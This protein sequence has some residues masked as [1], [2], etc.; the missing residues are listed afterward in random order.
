[1]LPDLPDSENSEIILEGYRVQVLATQSLE[2][3]GKLKEFLSRK[4]G[5]EVYIKFEAPN[6]KVRIGNFISKSEAEEL[7]TYFNSTGYPQ[8]WIIRSRINLTD[9]GL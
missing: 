4:Y 1:L 3:A 8:A 9:T 2:K 7:R 6:Y 5:S